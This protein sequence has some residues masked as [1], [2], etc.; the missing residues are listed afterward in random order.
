MANQAILD[1]K[2]ATITKDEG[3]GK[4]AILGYEIVLPIGILQSTVGVM[5]NKHLIE[6]FAVGDYVRVIGR[7]MNQTIIADVIQKTVNDSPFDYLKGVGR[8]ES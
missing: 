2:I 1:G 7:I 4:I 5:S 3:N 8:E 6:Q